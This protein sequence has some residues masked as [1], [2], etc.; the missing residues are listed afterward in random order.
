MVTR[1][2]NSPAM[3]P[4]N[5]LVTLQLYA[6]SGLRPV[7]VAIVESA[8]STIRGGSTCTV[9]SRL[10]D[11]HEIVKAVKLKQSCSGRVHDTWIAEEERTWVES[12]NNLERVAATNIIND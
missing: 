10:A 12:D 3:L 4:L 11:L 9:L 8:L 6:V 1:A 2:A 7:I 5:S